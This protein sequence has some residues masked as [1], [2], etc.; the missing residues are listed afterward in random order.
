MKPTLLVLSLF[1]II[2][3]ATT[4]KAEVSLTNGLIAF[5][6]FEGN[7]VDSSGSG[8]NATPAGN[9]QFVTN[10]V[11][12]NAIRII[13]DNSLFYSGGGHVLLPTFDASLNSGAAF[14]FWVRDEVLGGYPVGE[15]SYMSF[16]ALGL[17]RVEVYLNSPTQEKMV[18]VMCSGASVCWTFEQKVD[19][20]KDRSRWKHIVYSISP[21]NINIYLDAR[22]CLQ[23]NFNYNIFPVTKAAL[24]R[25]W[26]NSGASS[27]ARMSATY[28]NVRIYNRTITA[29]EVADL[30]GRESTGLLLDIQTAGFKIG[31]FAKSNI[32]YQV[33][34]TTDFQ[35]WSNLTSVA[36]QN[37]Y[38]NV[39]DW[40]DGGKR[41]YRVEAQ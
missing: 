34:W 26:W 20:N 13:G 19:W 9:F 37:A 25:H 18:F 36:G 22:L 6:K 11:F 30:Y 16:G 27:S 31:W 17:P 15:E 7:G 4:S 35:S 12:G 10:G 14:S 23:T 1:C 24:G 21:T 32:T 3:S 8:N 2:Q 40:N 5:Y 39:L 29:N 38:T 41:Y 33:Q 28:D